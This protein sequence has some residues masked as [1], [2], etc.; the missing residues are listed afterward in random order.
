MKKNIL[1]AVFSA[2][3]LV[4]PAVTIAAPVVYNVALPDISTFDNVITGTGSTVQVV[5]V[6]SGSSV[7]NY[8]DSNNVVQTLTVTRSNGSAITPSGGYSS[9]NQTLSGAVYDISPS[10]GG[11]IP[12]QNSGLKFTFSSAVNAFGFE[13]GDWATCCTTNTRSAAV[14]AAYGVPATGSGL[15]IA[16]DGGAATLPANALSSGDNPGYFHQTS[17]RQ[18]NSYTN[19]IGAID[20]S[21]TFSSI[22]FFGDGFGEFLVAGGSFRFASVPLGSVGTVPEPTS[23]ALMGLALAGLAVARR[24]RNA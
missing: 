22:N 9:G 2:S 17:G 19:F 14:Q 20:S 21:S 24:R 18:D 6:L 23:L 15:W 13:I 8:T 7:Y 11:A 10:S 12:G 5:K 4:F 16:F 3:A 1:M